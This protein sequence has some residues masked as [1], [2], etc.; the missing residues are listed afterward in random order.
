M[1]HMEI[2]SFPAG[3]Y[4]TNCYVVLSE[5]SE[6]RRYASVIDPGLRAKELID[7]YCEENRVEVVQVLLTHG[8]I[9]HCRDAA[10]LANGWG[11]ALQI[12]RDDEFFLDKGNGMSEDSRLLFHADAMNLPDSVSY[13]GDGDEVELGGQRFV[14]RHAPGHSPGCVLFVGKDFCFSGDVLFKGSIGRT[15]LAHSDPHAMAN[16]IKSVVL[17]LEDSLTIL[18]GHGPATTMRAEKASNP[19]LRV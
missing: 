5:E 12:H 8:H 14:V 18:P 2:L 11:V 7:Q 15:D 3:P 13:L 9:D 1:N 17:G 19:Y 16:S 4:Q 6:G 10:A